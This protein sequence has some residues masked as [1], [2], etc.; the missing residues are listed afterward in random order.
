M[1][2]AILCWSNFQQHFLMVKKFFTPV[3]MHLTSEFLRGM[4]I[5]TSVF[6]AGISFAT[7]LSVDG[8]NHLVKSC[9]LDSTCQRVGTFTTLKLR[10]GR[11]IDNVWQ[12]LPIPRR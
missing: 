1:T 4:S 6:L 5:A 12:P 2:Q 11:K 3:D 7:S 10:G 8:R 9:H